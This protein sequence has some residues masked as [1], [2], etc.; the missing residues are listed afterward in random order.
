M[1]AIGHTEKIDCDA[2]YGGS[3]QW[4]G[5]G[6]T[7][8]LPPG[9]A[10]ETVTVTLGAYLPSSTQEHCLLSAVFDVT[11]S[12]E[13]FNEPVTVRIPH[14]ANITCEE[15]KERLRFLILEKDTHE[16]KK[17]YFEIGKSFGSIEL[18]KF[19][20]MSIVSFPFSC[21]PFS[22]LPSIFPQSQPVNDENSMQPSGK[23]NV[24]KID[25]KYLD[26]LILPKSLDENSMW[27]GK[28]LVIPDI[29]TY[30]K[31]K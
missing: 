23:A 25:K 20:Y 18:T 24:K 21:L 4:K 10:D 2:K 27:F 14:C 6:F 13:T 22:C 29:F 30:W 31:V 12:I 9:C 7:I 28:Y 5:H 16:F 3:Y 17:G 11:T 8:M 26:V 19:C 15:D 1:I